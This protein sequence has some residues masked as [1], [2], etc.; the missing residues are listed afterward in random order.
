MRTVAEIQEAITDELKKVQNE[1]FLTAFQKLYDCA[2]ACTYA[3]G[4]YFKCKKDMSSILKKISPKTFGPQCVYEL[5][6]YQIT[7]LRVLTDCLKLPFKYWL[8]HNLLL[9]SCMLLSELQFG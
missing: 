8:L 9:S 7:R 6:N 1:E 4:A 5:N 3:N 2:K